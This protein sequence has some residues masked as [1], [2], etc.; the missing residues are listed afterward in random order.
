MNV[1]MLARK[2]PYL[3]DTTVCRNL[4]NM[5]KSFVNFKD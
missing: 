4:I 1:K 2:L 5:Y 3:L